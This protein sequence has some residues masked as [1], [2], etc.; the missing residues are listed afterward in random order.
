[1]QGAAGERYS[2]LGAWPVLR[3]HFS[4]PFRLLGPWS[5]SWSSVV[6]KCCKPPAHCCLASECCICNE[7]CFSV[8]NLLW[9]HLS[10]LGSSERLTSTSVVL[11]C[12]SVEKGDTWGEQ[13]SALQMRRFCN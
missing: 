6:V 12:I 8:L 2:K 10:W 3:S 1:M 7:V 13:M 11:V 4:V 5:M 9:L